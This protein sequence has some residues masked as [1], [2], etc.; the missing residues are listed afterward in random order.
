MSAPAEHEQPESTLQRVEPT[1]V[2]ERTEPLKASGYSRLFSGFIAIACL[3]VLTMGAWLQP[4]TDGHG[5]HTQLGLKPCMWAV[6]LDK[7]CMTCGMTTSF[8]HAGEGNWLVSFLTQPMG[9]LLVVLT[10]IV[11]WG[12]LVQTV[13][14]ARIGT[15]IQPALR[16]RV[17]FALGILMLLAWGYKVITW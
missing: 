9:S 12:A 14:G 15:M 8:A 10:S 2:V 16:P 17:F 4:S 7:P 6:T 11:F 5:T 1:R 13:S 3:S